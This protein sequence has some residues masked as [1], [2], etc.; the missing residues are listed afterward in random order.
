MQIKWQ[1]AQLAAA[2]GIDVTI[3]N[4]KIRLPYMR[5]WNKNRSERYFPAKGHPLRIVYTKSAA[6]R[7]MMLLLEG[8]EGL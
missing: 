3:T 8:G 6:G 4:G 5:F 7:I 2:Q 1:A